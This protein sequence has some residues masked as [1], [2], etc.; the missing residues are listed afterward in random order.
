VI[1][2]GNLEN[3]TLVVVTRRGEQFDRR[4]IEGFKFVPLIGKMGWDKLPLN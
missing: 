2:V 3:Q 1:P 4:E